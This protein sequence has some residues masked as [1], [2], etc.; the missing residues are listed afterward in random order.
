MPRKMKEW[1]SATL[2]V[3]QECSVATPVAT[4]DL[5]L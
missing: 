4:R 2:L 5:Q 3:P 1:S